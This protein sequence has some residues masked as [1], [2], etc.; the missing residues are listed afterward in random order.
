[1]MITLMELY[2]MF[3]FH[4]D[5]L[6]YYLY[7]ENEEDCIINPAEMDEFVDIYEGRKVE[8]VSILRDSGNIILSVTLGEEL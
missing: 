8:E 2:N 4:P 1:M 5:K 6:Y 3:E 7:K